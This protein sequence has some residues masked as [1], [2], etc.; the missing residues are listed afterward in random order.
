[1][2]GVRPQQRLMA[3][4]WDKAATR[5]DTKDWMIGTTVKVTER[6]VPITDV[7]CQC[8]GLRSLFAVEATG[9]N[10]PISGANCSHRL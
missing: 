1:M 5:G 6:L 8:G 4:R 7:L 9:E 3:G 10:H 2:R